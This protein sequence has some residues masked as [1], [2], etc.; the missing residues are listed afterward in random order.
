MDRNEADCMYKIEGRRLVNISYFWDQIKQ[1]K[2]MPYF[3]CDI[4]SCDIV[5]ESTKGY[6]SCF[7]IKC[8]MCEA[9][10]RIDTDDCS[11]QFD[12]N[13]ATVLGK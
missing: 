7:T 9:I 6:L 4:T 1:I 3:N 5:Q 2:H 10:S 13:M 11:Q 8:R 12:V